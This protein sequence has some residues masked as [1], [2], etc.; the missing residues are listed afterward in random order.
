MRSKPTIGRFPDFDN[1]LFPILEAVD[2]P[3]TTETYMT[4]LSYGDQAKSIVAIAT[5]LQKAGLLNHLRF[6]Q[7]VNR[8]QDIHQFQDIFSY[9]IETRMLT[10]NYF[11]LIIRLNDSAKLYYIYALFIL[12][13]N[14]PAFTADLFDAILNHQ[15]ME[16]IVELLKKHLTKTNT[17]LLSVI[18]TLLTENLLTQQVLSKLNKCA[19]FEEF[20]K[21]L[22]T[23]K[24]VADAYRDD[25]IQECCLF[26]F[27]RNKKTSP[28]FATALAQFSRTGHYT[29]FQKTISDKT[30][31]KQLQSILERDDN[32]S[33]VRRISSIS[34]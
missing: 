4:F 15:H 20:A 11:D 24:R 19:D 7:I 8:R 5:L 12:K 26:S 17:V 2:I 29:L 3:I 32:A 27:F 13:N 18:S 31:D 21:D 9:L 10:E 28:A 23:A 25:E 34:R 16:L 30:P 33:I 1:Q 14:H 22:I 6:N